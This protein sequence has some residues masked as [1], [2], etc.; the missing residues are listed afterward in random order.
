MFLNRKIEASSIAEVVIAISV[1]ALCIGIASLVFVRATK[2]T[3]NFQ[4]VRTQTE[5]QSKLWNN[6]FTLE[7]EMAD[8]EGITI[9]KELTKNDSIQHLVFLG[10]DG[11]IILKQDWWVE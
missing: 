11:K 8:I 6:L 9:E 2:S 3:I 10:S 5:I 7:N 4:E 1:I